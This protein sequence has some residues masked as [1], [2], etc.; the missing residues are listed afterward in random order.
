MQNIQ[1]ITPTVCGMMG[2]SV[3][4]LCSVGA[5]EK[6]IGEAKSRGVEKI[7]RCLLYAP[8]AV[9]GRWLQKKYNDIFATVENASDVKVELLSVY[10]PKTP[11]C[12][13]SMFTGATPQVH[14]VVWPARPVLKCDT[15]FDAMLRAGKRVAIAAV[16]GSS[17]DTMYK[18]RDIDYY[19]ENYDEE[20]IAR[21]MELVNRNEHDFIVSYNQE[22]DDKLHQ[23][24]PETKEAIEAVE[25]HCRNFIRLAE[26]AG[27]GWKG[28]KS[29]IT[30]CPD[31]GGHFDK[32][33]QKG[34]HGENIPEDMEICHFFKIQA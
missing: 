33:G 27:E 6:I 17:I 25:R 7:T 5:I 31:H 3:P 10:P 12:F 15:I 9:G 16:A 23:G 24:G 26:A 34:T 21:T 14:G 1:S 19:S 32:A 22:Y 8:D 11:V 28:H 20:V 4:G 29:L 13:A 18:G 30:F 2:V